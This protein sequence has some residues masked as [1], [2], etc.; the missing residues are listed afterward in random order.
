MPPVAQFA[1][2]Y[3]AG[4]WAGRAAFLPTA[5][6]ASGA[7]AIA[8]LGGRLPWRAVLAATVL[9][10]AARG[11]LARRA[12]AVTCAAT[13][14][15]GRHVVLLRLGDAPDARGLARGDVL[16][17]PERC[18]GAL[19]V[20][21][22]ATVPSGATLLLAGR[23][24]A[25]GALRVE[26][27]RVLRRPRP[28]RFVLRDA[29]SARIARLYGPRAPLVDALV[30]GRRTGIDASLRA[31]FAASG[32]AH[33]LSISGLHV[34]IAAA[35]LVM[36][37][38]A[39]G[40]RRWLWPVTVI[41]TWAYVAFLGFP[42]PAARSAGFIAVHALAR[43]RQRHPP[44]AAVLAVGGLTVLAVDPDAITAVGAWL[45]FAA[46]WGTG[47]AMAAL[48]PT[49]RS[50]V[51]RLLAASVGAT[52]AT[53]PITALTFGAV[54]PIGVL[55]NLGA[56]PL[57]GI[58]V[59][60]VFASLIGGGPLAGG[61]GLVLAAIERIAS[62]AAAV[63]FGHVQ[64]DPGPWLAAPW[65]GVLAA[66]AWWHRRRPARRLVEQRFAALAAV[67]AWST[68]A[69]AAWPAGQYDG[70]T[71]HVLS[72]GQGD[73]IAIR[74]P[75]GR[76]MLVDGGPRTPAGD[77]GRRVVVPFL[78]HQGARAL[79]VV[80]VSHAD[81]DHLGGIPATL[82]AL[83]AGTVL[84]PG[85]PV[86]TALYLEFLAVVDRVGAAWQP[87]RAG[88]RIELDGVRVEVLHPTARWRQWDV[89]TNE[90]SV[91]LR[92]SYGAFD[93]LL[94]GDVGF[95]A[96]SVLVD[97]VGRAEVLKV[98][99]HGSAGSSSGRWLDAVGPRVAV[100][101]VGPN[102]FGHPA[103]PT[104][105]RL[106]AHGVDVYRTDRGGTVTIRSDGRY[107]SVA[108]A[109]ANPLLERFLCPILDWLPSRASS[110]SRSACTPR[111]R[112]SS[113]TSYTTWPSPP[114]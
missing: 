9:A 114:R 45:S 87:A 93:A 41:A 7:L 49:R 99:H 13:W 10:G 8:L 113:P 83:P 16:H 71:I 77:A 28:L 40:L 63:P 106:A 59:P 111:P 29:A 96:E 62:I 50:G 80:V 97:R 20:R 17:A 89:R 51:W 91:V 82:S 66:A 75:H 48:P 74:S 43:A 22:V 112:G 100:I 79:D 69:V 94:A 58:A 65:L 108:H 33:L 30:T 18:G 64:G 90:N 56:V 95:A 32:L 57:A 103:A 88:D 81:A 39:L 38:R 35:W 26:H 104:L 61:T 34:G 98:G 76:W 5:L 2:A 55:A 11:G 52:V 31:D 15:P 107:F 47:A 6:F 19:M 109:R 3:A 42:A 44:G 53:A 72:V 110:S 78:R 67:V 105:A 36:L 12:E 86:G 25:P 60:G 73:A 23:Y 21:L 92:V 4:L 37:L 27:Y 102:G 85:Q 84:E 101:S 68:V 70:L 24:Q 14:A 1:S 46:V 54:A